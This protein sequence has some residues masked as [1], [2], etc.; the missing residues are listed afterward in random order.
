MFCLEIYRIKIKN[1]F[2]IFNLRL[3][4]KSTSA[5]IPPEFGIFPGACS[6][7]CGLPHKEIY[8]SF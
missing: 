3:K 7:L 1:V 2:Q 6:D 4:Q 5:G 8:Y